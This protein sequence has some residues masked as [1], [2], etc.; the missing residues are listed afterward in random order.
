[1]SGHEFE[2]V[3]APPLRGKSSGRPAG[4]EWAL[5]RSRPGSWALIRSATRPSSATSLMRAH[6]GFEVIARNSRKVNGRT[7][8]DIFARY[9]GEAT[10]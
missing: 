5:L 9:I 10:S 7:V 3:E 8:C 6:P 1:M 2:W 4:P